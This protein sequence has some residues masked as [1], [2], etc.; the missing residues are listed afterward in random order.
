MEYEV[1]PKLA[2]RGIL[3]DVY[4]YYVNHHGSES[5]SHIHF[6]NKI[7]PEVRIISSGTHGTY[8]HP[9]KEAIERL[10]NISSDIFQ[11][12][13]NIDVDSFPDIIKNVSDEFIGNFDCVGDE[14]SILIEVKDDTYVVKI[15]SR[16]IEKAYS[17]E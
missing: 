15:L 12:N 4:V 3:K 9:R 11:L 8:M 13:K 5:S 7:K 2:E 6:L 14:G 17:I 1:E 16:G 10:E